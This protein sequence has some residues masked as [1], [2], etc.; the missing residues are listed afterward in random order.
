MRCPC[1]SVAMAMFAALALFPAAGLRADPC[2]MVPP[3]YIGDDVPIVRVGEQRT[4][5][6]YWKGIESFVI[7]P[8]FSGKVA[9]FGML[10]PFPEPPAIRKV[11]DGIFHQIANAIDPPEI[12]VDLRPPIGFGL[13][14][15]GGG[16]FGGAGF[17]GG[18]FGFAA[19][20]KDEVRVI[21]EEAVGMYEVA[22]LA[23]GSAKALKRWIDD[24]GYKFPA[25]MDKTCEEYVKEGWCFVAVKTKVG[26]SSGATPKPGQRKVNTKLP[27]GATFDGRVQ[28][29]AFRFRSEHLVVPMRLSAFNAGSLRNIVYLLSDE[30]M[31][32]RSIPEEYVVRQIYGKQLYKNLT[33]PLPLRIIGGRVSDISKKRWRELDKER[34]PIPH[35]GL[36]RD[37]FAADLLAAK[38]GR[39]INP[40]EQREKRLTTVA[41]RLGLRGSEVDKLVRNE[42]RRQR[43]KAVKSSLSGLRQ[44]TLTVIDGDFPREAI[45]KQ[46]LTFASYRMKS[47][48]NKPVFYD[49]KKMG[50]GGKKEGILK[51][52]AIEASE[53]DAPVLVDTGSP[54]DPPRRSVAA[55]II[56][57]LLVVGLLLGWVS[58]RVRR[59]T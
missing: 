49:A 51:L 13:G 55:G 6:F 53:R 2:G 42:V 11:D 50:P 38:R 4:Y 3:V 25:G 37:L 26:K 15:G 57:S 47:T 27:S 20:K 21:R 58:R 17:G 33:E 59:T 10:I 16:S 23:A 12:V 56:A 34:N 46:N 22:V 48:R 30:G 14:G 5:V 52:G 29:M 54:D 43:L 32:I 19:P 41:E 1:P 40:Y 35:N 9:E 44:M 39:L 18:G 7:R 28:A 31:R 45:A 36:A 8:G 24:H